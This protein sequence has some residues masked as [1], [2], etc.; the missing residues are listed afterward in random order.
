M[1]S[2]AALLALGLLSTVAAFAE[3]K[4]SVDFGGMEIALGMPRAA[5]LANAQRYTP[6]CFDPEE[7]DVKRCRTVALFF[8]RES[9]VRVVGLVRF[10]QDRVV[11]VSKRWDEAFDGTD[12]NRFVAALFD[13]LSNEMGK[14]DSITATVSL[15]SR[16]S[17]QALI[18]QI[19]LRTDRR[20]I[21]IMLFEDVVS[22]DG[23]RMEAM[24]SLAEIIN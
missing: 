4:D 18:R 20:T 22:A 14:R 21:S 2:A 5:V 12:P 17:P 8:T 23:R 7:E 15:T 1:K 16:R 6:M 11:E 24:V 13:L 19:D 3:S 9:A 10:G